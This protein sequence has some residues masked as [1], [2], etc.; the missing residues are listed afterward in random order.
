M[1][2]SEGLAIV[3]AALANSDRLALVRELA[4][5]T[6][7]RGEDNRVATISYLA[8]RTEMSRFSTSRH[9]RILRECGLA[10]ARRDGT[11]ILHRLNGDILNAID[12]WLYP[13]LPSSTMASMTGAD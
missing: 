7:T 3:F 10:R 11:R 9:L 6:A 12:D 1:K 8:A 4:A 5:T 2:D 13:L